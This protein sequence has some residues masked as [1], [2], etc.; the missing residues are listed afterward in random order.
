MV[1]WF[2][3]WL[4]HLISIVV[5]CMKCKEIRVLNANILGVDETVT[6]GDIGELYSTVPVGG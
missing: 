5:Y 3:I 6:S 1:S 2:V 4:S